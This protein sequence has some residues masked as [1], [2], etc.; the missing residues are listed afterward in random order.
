MK[1]RM[2]KR[3]RRAQRPRGEASFL[4]NRAVALLRLGERDTASECVAEAR[5][6]HHLHQDPYVIANWASVSARLAVERGDLLAGRR[7]LDEAQGVLGCS[8]LGLAGV[9]RGG[10]LNE[11]IGLL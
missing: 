5:T 2:A 8:N 1:S 9:L 3:C 11:D 6:L 10:C 4:T 7:L